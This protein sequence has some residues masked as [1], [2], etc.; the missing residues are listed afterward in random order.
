[1]RFT[2]QDMTADEVWTLINNDKLSAEVL[3]LREK[4]ESLIKEVGSLRGELASV[5]RRLDEKVATCEELAAENLSLYDRLT[6]PDGASSETSQVRVIEW[7][8]VPELAKRFDMTCPG[9]RARIKSHG[10]PYKIDGKSGYT[11][12]AA[13]LEDM[14]QKPIMAC[15][16]KKQPEEAVSLSLKSSAEEIGEEVKRRASLL[17][18]S[19]LAIWQA[20]SKKLLAYS[21]NL[22]EE[23][24][25]AG[26]GKKL[27]L[28]AERV[29][30]GEIPCLFNKML[31]VVTCELEEQKLA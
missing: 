15:G 19:P 23:A 14:S 28:G 18:C 24:K 12:L 10:L 8:A 27:A 4:C 31:D 6:S 2:V 26:N 7:V 21:Y 29:N 17:N 20:V 30:H 5:R 9:V 22:R 1:M 3:T 11:D 16:K 25:L 13:W